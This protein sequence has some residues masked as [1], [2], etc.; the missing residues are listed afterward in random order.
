MTTDPKY[1]SPSIEEFHVG[2][3]YEYNNGSEWTQ[4]V[5]PDLMFIDGSHGEWFPIL[6]SLLQDEKIRV[7]L[8]DRE[9]I[10][11]EGMKFSYALFI[12]AC[13]DIGDPYKTGGG[14]LHLNSS[15]EV[16]ISLNFGHHEIDGTPKDET[17]FSG[18][19]RNRSELKR[20]L[21]QVGIK[22]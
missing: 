3:E 10:E 6:Q 17:V 20:I 14:F 22:K 1:Y 4:Q 7:K 8:L 11:A 15:G 12:Q 5:F 13:F 21:K 16:S 9:D 2:F 18:T 19:I